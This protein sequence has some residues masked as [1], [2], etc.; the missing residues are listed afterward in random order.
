MKK[1]LLVIVLLFSPLFWRGVGGEAQAQIITTIAGN[2]MAAYSG[3]GGQGANAELYLAQSGGT[4]LHSGIAIDASGNLYIA[5][6]YNFRIR[7][8]IASTGIISTVA[9]SGTAGYSGDGGHATAA[10]LLFPSGVALDVAGNIYIADEGNNRIR[11]VNTSG[12][13]TTIA[14]NGTSGY[15]GDGS[16]ATAAELSGPTGI[17]IDAAGNI[18]I[19]DNNNNRIREVTISTSVIT[20]IAGNGTGAY[21]GD[22]GAATAAELYGPCSVVLDATGNIYIADMFNNLIR[23]ITT[24]TG[25]ISSVAGGGTLGPNSVPATSVALQSPTGLDFDLGGNMFISYGVNR[26]IKVTTSTGIATTVAGTTGG[27]EIFIGDGGLATAAILNIPGD[28]AIDALGNIYIADEH[29]NRIRM[30]CNA[31]D[32]VSGIITAPSSSPITAG[33]VYVFRPKNDSAVGLLDTAGATTI[34]ANGAYTFT[35]LPYANYYIEAK[36]DTTAYPTAVGTYYSTKSNN[37][38][39]DSA[40]FVNHRGCANTSYSGYNI[41]VIETPAQTGTGVISGNVT[42]L[43]S[44]GH[45]LAGSYNNTMGAVKSIDVKLGKKPAG[46]CTN[47]TSTDAAGNYSFTGLDTGT[48]VV[49]VDIPNFTDTLVNLTVTPTNSVYTNVN[50]CVD[51]VK[52]HFCGSLTSGIKQLAGITEHVSVYPNPNNGSFTIKLNEYENTTVEVYNT[53]GQ[54]VLAQILQNNLTQL[55]LANCSNGMYQLRVLKN[56]TPVYQTK[57]VKQE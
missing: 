26:I 29:N 13:I 18:Y 38:Q 57:V 49:Y 12:I 9:G 55:N 21:S 35:N 7:K 52:V 1:H 8:L 25:I 32:N 47:R 36:A 53:I 23:L 24:S 20:T 19:A 44:Y 46:G 33:Q 5:D 50:Y 45:R 48:Y 30:V 17:A 27:S 34:Q 54:R 16:N 11:K 14:G 42:A 15:A 28:V 6:T 22:G 37:Y 2:G 40:I 39:W 10:N 56:N 43:A 41:T 31:A 51:S 4:I 3:D